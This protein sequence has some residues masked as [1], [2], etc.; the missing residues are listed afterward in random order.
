MVKTIGEKEVGA[1]VKKNT[2]IITTKLDVTDASATKVLSSYTNKNTIN[3]KNIGLNNCYF[4]FDT[5][6]TTSNIMIKSGSEITFENTSFDNISAICDTGEITELNLTISCG[7][8]GQ[9]TNSEI[10]SISTTDASSNESFSDT[11]NYK[12]LYIINEGANDVYINFGATATTDNLKL[13]SKA[14]IAIENTNKYQ[15]SSI[16]AAGETSTIKILGVY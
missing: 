13:I 1:I 2:N 4:V 5:S 7:Q 16:C 10:I 9:K 6:A 11:T 14:V 8:I 15:I 3:I 12:D